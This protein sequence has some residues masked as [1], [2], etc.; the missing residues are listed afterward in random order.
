MARKALFDH[1][2]KS[3]ADPQAQRPPRR[4][5]GPCSG[6]GPDGSAKSATDRTRTRRRMAEVAGQWC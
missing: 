5:E 4:A 1:C 3:E 6:S 2:A